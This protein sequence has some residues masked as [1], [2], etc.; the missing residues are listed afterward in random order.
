MA[1]MSSSSHPHSI[2]SL[3]GSRQGEARSH[4]LRV[5]RRV[6]R[7]SRIAGRAFLPDGQH[8]LFTSRNRGTYLASLDSAE[9]PR[10]L[11]E[12]STNAMFQR[13]LSD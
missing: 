11:L 3:C 13:R 4:R 9:P 8:F 1:R 5:W 2:P 12:E 7:R 6:S 10:R